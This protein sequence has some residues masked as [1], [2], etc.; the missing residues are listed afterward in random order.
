MSRKLFLNNVGLPAEDHGGAPTLQALSGAAIV[1]ST[2]S[3]FLAGKHAIAR[4]PSQN[5]RCLP[6]GRWA[7][8]PVA[9]CDIGANDI[10]VGQ[11]TSSIF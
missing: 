2:H 10:D 3:E 1:Y 5:I 11:C 6:S 4:V 9:F 8:Y 7:L